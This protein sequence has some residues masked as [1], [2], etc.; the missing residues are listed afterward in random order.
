MAGPEHPAKIEAHPN[1]YGI[2]PGPTFIVSDGI[3]RKWT[4]LQ[5]NGFLTK[6]TNHRL[7]DL[8]FESYSP[9]FD[10]PD[11][12]KWTKEHAIQVGSA[13]VK[14][15]ASQIKVKLGEGNAKFDQQQSNG[16]YHV[17]HWMIWWP[18]VDSEGH[19]FSNDGIIMEIPEGY[20]PMFVQIKQETVFY[21]E[22]GESIQMKEALKRAR[23]K[24]ANDQSWDRLKSIFLGPTSTG[25][26][27]PNPT[28][29]Y[30]QI[31]TPRTR[32]NASGRLA[33]VF[34]FKQ[35]YQPTVNTHYPISFWIDAYTGRWIGGDVV[36]LDTP[37]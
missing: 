17:G 5:S 10:R 15:L 16:R 4:F 31:V 28:N 23:S 27:D 35:H 1:E 7:F 26:T 2:D 25:W 32:K 20:G 18:R 12:P 13:F 34:W 8:L 3:S 14:A 21:E 6:Y 37:D 33:W 29:A 11:T 36:G 9:A 22:R 19:P 24:I 30:L